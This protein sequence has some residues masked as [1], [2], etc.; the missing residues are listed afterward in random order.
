MAYGRR[1]FTRGR[2]RSNLAFRQGGTGATYSGSQDII[3][4]SNTHSGTIPTGYTKTLP[5]VCYNPDKATTP[6]SVDG[7]S[8]KVR[9]SNFCDKGSRVDYV[10]VQLTLNQSDTSKNN[11]CYIGTM[12]TSFNQARL[13]ATLMADQFGNGTTPLI[14][15][16][17]DGEMNVQLDDSP[18]VTENGAIQLTLTQYSVKDILQHNLRH[19]SRPQFQLYSGRVITANQVIPIPRRNKRQQEGSLFAL[20]IMND[21]T[22]GAN[23]GTDVEYRLDTFFKEIPS[24]TVS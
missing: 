21:S 3:R 20:A 4:H 7:S 9:Y 18:P 15:D 2:S 22:V 12:S 10:T 5:L 24:T 19:L 23:P 8:A 6:Y 1:R 16:E 17:G 11:T 14:I 13:D